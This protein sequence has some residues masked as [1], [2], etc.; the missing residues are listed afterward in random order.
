MKRTVPSFRPGFEAPVVGDVM[1]CMRSFRGLVVG[2]TSFAFEPVVPLV[3]LAPFKSS[4]TFGAG[5]LVKRG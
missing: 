4:A 5:A 1:S 2:V 3:A